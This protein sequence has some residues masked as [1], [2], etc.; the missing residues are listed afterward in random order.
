MFSLCLRVKNQP[1]G[2]EA[3]FFVAFETNGARVCVCVCV[4]VLGRACVFVCVCV[5]VCVCAC[6]RVCLV[7]FE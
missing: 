5:C 6:V 3:F 1:L 4:A 7:A 2:R